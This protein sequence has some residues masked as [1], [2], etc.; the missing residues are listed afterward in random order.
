MLNNFKQAWREVFSFNKTS[1]IQPGSGNNNESP[2]KDTVEAAQGKN[3]H[4]VKY[5]ERKDDRVSAPFGRNPQDYKNVLKPKYD[6]TTTTFITKSTVITGTIKTDSDL[7]IA[8][9]IEGNVEGRNIAI[10][11]GKIFGDIN[12]TSTEIDDAHIEGNITAVEMID[13]GKDNMILGNIS[14]NR[15]KVA[16]KVR[17]HVTVKQDLEIEE[18]AIILG[19]ITADLLSIKKGAALYGNMNVRREQIS[20]ITQKLQQPQNQSNPDPEDS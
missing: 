5:P 13:I 10:I 15:G 6:E 20:T 1:G 16:G 8:G 14:A 17:G 2:K 18:E 12:C 9:K 19:D 3:P 7:K 11:G 4:P